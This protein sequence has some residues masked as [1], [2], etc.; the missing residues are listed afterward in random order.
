V[1]ATEHISVL[2]RDGIL[3]ADAATAAGLTAAVPPCPGW[4]IR[5]LV[6]HQAYVHA[7]AARHVKEQL[8]EL[9]DEATEDEILSGG[10]PDAELIAAY[11]AGHVALVA[12]LR[13]ADPDVR[14]ATFMRAPS[15]LAFW[16]RRQAHET[17]IHRFDA[18]TA[19][20][21]APGSPTEAF[22]PAFA[23]DG[24]DELIM[25]FAA[26]RRYRLQDPGESSLAVRATDTGGRWHV[27][28]ADGRTAVARGDQPAECVLE[29]PA[30][31]LY[32]FLWNR[33]DSAT[34]QVTASGDPAVLDLWGSSVRVRW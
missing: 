19:G 17:A 16:A 7:W 13:E 2:E 24:V 21:H 11:R 5:D 12:V 30:A 22:E 32:A 28:I 33:C 14:C 6:R 15:P 10:P 1:D 23:D 29:G 31:G 34:A 25:G 26:R 20:K 4:Q 8:A 3:L 9:I 18:Q 27:R